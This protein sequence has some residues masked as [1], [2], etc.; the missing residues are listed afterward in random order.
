MDMN[1]T[2]IYFHDGRAWV[3]ELK[4]GRARVSS[5]SAWLTAHPGR[6][7]LRSLALELEPPPA[8][9]ARFPSSGRTRSGLASLFARLLGRRVS[10]DPHPDAG[11]V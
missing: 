5:L 11:G 7:A 3:A 2:T 1:R 10:P 6:G 9:R 4:G 8:P